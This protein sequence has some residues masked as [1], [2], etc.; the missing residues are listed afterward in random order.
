MLLVVVRNSLKLPTFFLLQH[1]LDEHEFVD[2][3]PEEVARRGHHF[4]TS[5]RKASPSHSKCH[6]I[7]SFEATHPRK[8]NKR[9]GVM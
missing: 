9:C 2:A 6:A 8:P 1:G 4:Q 7:R 5:S 3:D